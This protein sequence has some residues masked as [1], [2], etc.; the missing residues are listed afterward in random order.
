MNGY[1]VFDILGPIMIGPSSSHTAGA[2]RI[3]RNATSIVEPEFKSVVFELHGSFAKTYQGHGTDRALLAG[4][5]GYR[6]DDIKIR[7]AF[8]IAEKTGLKYE[9]RQAD[10]GDVH[11]N[12]VKIV[13]RYADGK[14]NY[15][16][17]SSIGGGM[18]EIFSFNGLPLSFDGT[19]PTI[20]VKYKD[21]IG[22]ISYVSTELMWHEYNIE[23]M[24]TLKGE[25]D[26]ITLIVELD[27]P[28]EGD[29]DD[30]I[31]KNKRFAFA[32]YIPPNKEY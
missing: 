12:T 1:G 26:M 9:F 17:G 18:I 27:R 32:K 8:E 3:A 5:L 25:G 30:S 16:T 22:M 21:K 2:C 24:K 11:P 15:V 20:M 29:L 4:V 6:P 23:S 19:F 10:L 28:V 31:L 13:Y 14:E 7:D